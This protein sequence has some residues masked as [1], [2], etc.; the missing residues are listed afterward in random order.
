MYGEPGGLDGAVT[1]PSV[2]KKLGVA[3]RYEAATFGLEA[4]KEEVTA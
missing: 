1:F 4:A 3:N 2:L